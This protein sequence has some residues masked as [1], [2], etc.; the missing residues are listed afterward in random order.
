MLNSSCSGSVAYDQV[1][2]A[3]ARGIQFM[4]RTGGHSLT[5]SPRRI[6]DALVIDMRGLNTVRYDVAKQQMTVGCGVTTGEFADATFS[7][8]MEVCKYPCIQLKDGLQC[9]FD[10]RWVLSVY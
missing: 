4:A 10:S 8:G 5:T 2:Y 6:Q 1:N 7:R 9:K 3:R